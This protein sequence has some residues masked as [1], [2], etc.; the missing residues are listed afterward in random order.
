M[1]SLETLP[2]RSALYLPASN[3][4]AIAKARTLDADMIILDLE[5]AV[6]EADKAT[7]RDAAAA[8]MDEGFGDRIA[9]IRINAPDSPH[10][11]EDVVAAQASQTAAI[12]IPKVEMAES[13]AQIARAVGKPVLAMIETPAGILAAASIAA[14]DGVVG[15]IAGTNDIA[16]ALR[17]PPLAGRGGL[18]LALQTIVLAGRAA[19]V[20]VIDGVWNRLDDPEGLEGECRE[21]RDLGFDGKTLIHPNQIAVANRAFSPSE[22]EIEDARALIEAAQGGAVRFRDRMVED[23]HVATA[24]A[25]LERAR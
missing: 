7:A 16:H 12:V 21:G 18:T 15:L 24:R 6:P 1:T 17:L 3:A 20:F 14:A 19:G 2:P 22:A 25:L 4:R 9:A 5:D 10:H 23:M 13:A 8:A 11:A